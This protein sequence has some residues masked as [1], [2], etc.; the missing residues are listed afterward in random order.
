MKKIE[1]KECHTEFG[2]FIKESRM[3]QNLSQSEVAD[4]VGLSQSYLSYIEKGK[5]D[6]DLAVA[7]K[8]CEALNLDI[9]EFISLY[10]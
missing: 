5:R 2:N 4:Q 1:I 10:I 6:V 9:R 8:I 7:M 3:R